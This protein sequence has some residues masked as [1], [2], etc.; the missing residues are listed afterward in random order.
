MNF[1]AFD[2]AYSIYPRATFEERR[3]LSFASLS[4]RDVRALGKYAL[5][6]WSIL[7]NIWPHEAQTSRASFY[8]DI[9]R[10][11]RDGRSWVV[12][13]NMKGVEPRPRPSPL[14]EPFPWD[15]VVHNSWTLV[16]PHS[17]SK[18]FMSYCILKPTIFRYAYLISDV[19]LIR[20]LIQFFKEQ[21]GIEH[22]KSA[23]IPDNQKAA[24]WTW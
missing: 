4:E 19:E 6:G 3:A 24:S 12:P 21:G 20:G 10:R 1:I 5:R 18:M 8:M 2:A 16:K 7:S 23:E 11:V 22:W 17:T 9:P 13:L 14:S 15:P